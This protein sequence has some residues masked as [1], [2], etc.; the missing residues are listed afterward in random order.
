[1]LIDKRWKT[2]LEKIKIEGLGAA[3]LDRNKQKKL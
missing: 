2:K 1:M 3:E